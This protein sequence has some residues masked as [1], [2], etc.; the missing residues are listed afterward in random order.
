MK[1]YLFNQV[2]IWDWGIQ[3]PGTITI[4][5]EVFIDQEWFIEFF[6]DFYGIGEEASSYDSVYFY[7]AVINFY[8]AELKKPDSEEIIRIHF[9]KGR[10]QRDEFKRLVA[11]YI[12]KELELEEKKDKEQIIRKIFK[13]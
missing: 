3:F 8:W 7:P 11:F 1:S 6:E 13:N 10:E 5:W 4:N 9:P 2:R 12:F